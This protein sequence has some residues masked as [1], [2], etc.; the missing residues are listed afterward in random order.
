MEKNTLDSSAIAALASQMGANT[1]TQPSSSNVM[2]LPQLTINSL[3]EDDDGNALPRGS[4]TIKGSEPVAFAESVTFRPLAHHFQY[5]E[6]D[7]VNN[8]MACKSKIIASFSDEPIDT[9]GTTRCGKPIS[10]DLRNMP[11]EMK[12]KYE[13]ITCF[14]QVRGLV[15]GTAKTATGEKVEWDNV[16]V[17]LMLKGTNFGPFEDEYLKPMPKNRN[18]WDFQATLSSKRHKNGNVVWFTFHF[19]PD[20]KNPL[21]LDEKVVETITTIADAIKS[22]NNRVKKAYDMALSSQQMD[23]QAIDALNNSLDDDL[24][25]GIEDAA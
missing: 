18:I 9:R 2:R 6:W 11:P 25:D 23:Q 15:S 8:R 10:R 17:I 1:N 7:K 14:R 16:P 4:F 3:P 20:F 19:S 12:A 13:D 22:E 24:E 5:L 21:G